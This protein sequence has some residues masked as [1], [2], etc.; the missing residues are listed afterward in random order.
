MNLR[1]LKSKLPKNGAYVGCTETSWDDERRTDYILYENETEMKE[2][3]IR[4]NSSRAYDTFYIIY[5]KPV[6]YKLDV[7]VNF[8]SDDW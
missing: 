4:R 1:D 5:M 6:E 2:D 7:S 3:I 8:A